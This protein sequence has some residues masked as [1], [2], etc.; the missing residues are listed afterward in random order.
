MAQME[1]G[2]RA[3]R[4]LGLLVVGSLFVV[5]LAASG[6]VG[7][8]DTGGDQAGCI[9]INYTTCVTPS[10]GATLTTTPGTPACIPINYTTCVPPVSGAPVNTPTAT[11]PANSL[12]TTYFDP[13]YCDGFVSIVTDGSGNLI[14][15][16]TTTGQR[17]FPVFPDFA[18][19]GGFVG[20]GY[21]PYFSGTGYAPA[22]VNGGFVNTMAPVASYAAYNGNWA[23]GYYGAPYYGGGTYQ[24]T[25]NRFCGDGQV[26]FSNGQYFCANGRPLYRS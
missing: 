10:S 2:R 23:Y 17:I 16:C 1:I 18:P 4:L 11:L 5:A 3:S 15:V 6:P 26:I 7:A 25:D 14:N 8:A 24:Y 9:P 20:N 12:V 22:Y 13:R 21:L 19:Y